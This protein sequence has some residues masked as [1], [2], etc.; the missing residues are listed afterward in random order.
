[1]L[2]PLDQ[3]VPR[4]ANALFN[5][6]GNHDRF[7]KNISMREMVYQAFQAVPFQ[8]IWPWQHKNI[9]LRMFNSQYIDWRL[10]PDDMRANRILN[11]PPS[12]TVAAE[13]GFC[14]KRNKIVN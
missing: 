3:R 12:R 2:Q 1:M 11:H 9:L 6:F 14:T 7:A 4:R 13:P 5:Q 10:N 8:Q